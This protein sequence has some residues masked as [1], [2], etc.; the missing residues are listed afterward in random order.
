MA[1]LPE[2]GPAKPCEVRPSSSSSAAITPST[3]PSSSPSPASPSSAPW[4]P[5]SSH[6]TFNGPAGYLGPI[7]LEV[8]PAAKER[9][10]RR[11]V[12]LDKA[13]EGRTNMVAGANKLDY[14]YR[15][16]TPGRDFN[17]DPHRRHPQRQRRRARPHRRQ[18]PQDRQG[19]RD[20][21]H[22]QARLQILEV[23]GRLRPQPRRQRGHAHHG[24]LR[25]RHR[26]HPHRRHRVLRRSQR[27]Q[28]PTRSTRPSRPS[29]SSSPSPTSATPALLAA[30]EKV[31]A[32]L[33]AAGIDV[34]LDDRDERA[35]V[36]FKD[37]DLVGIPYRINIG[38][39]VAEGKVELVD[40]L[41]LT[42]QDHSLDRGRHA[43][44]QLITRLN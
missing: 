42:N 24:Q 20:R 18:A 27:R 40:R 8:R 32:D 11:F 4:S 43:S 6:S 16:V 3:R 1:E 34:L 38:R 29:R 19:R 31:A 44:R 26:A 39:G 12:V 36:K 5:K 23:H 37:A 15:N 9:S 33:D 28:Q 41:K 30:G 22:L 25:H 17:L 35:G 13:L 21:P 10:A 7:G 2:D 14:H